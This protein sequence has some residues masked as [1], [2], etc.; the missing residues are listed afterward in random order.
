M[1]DTSV[2]HSINVL[3]GKLED[4]NDNLPEWKRA[5]LK[6]KFEECFDI[7]DSHERRAKDRRK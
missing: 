3:Q 2:L 4:I 5:A 1:T 6:K 7:I